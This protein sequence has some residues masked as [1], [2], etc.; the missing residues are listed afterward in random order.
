MAKKVTLEETVEKFIRFYKLIQLSKD[1]FESIDAN[2][3]GN[4]ETWFMCWNAGA[5]FITFSSWGRIYR[6][7]T[8]DYKSIAIS[9]T[10][11]AIISN[12]RRFW[13]E[14]IR[15]FNKVDPPVLAWD[16][17]V[18]IRKNHLEM[19]FPSIYEAKRYYGEN[20]NLDD[21]LTFDNT[22]DDSRYI[23]HKIMD[24]CYY[25]VN[26]VNLKKGKSSISL[27]PAT[28][29]DQRLIFPPIV[30]PEFEEERRKAFEVRKNEIVSILNSRIEQ[31]NN[32]LREPINQ[33]EELGKYIKNKK[34]TLDI[35]IEVFRKELN[36]LGYR[37]GDIGLIRREVESI[38]DKHELYRYGL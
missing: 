26:I 36:E 19:V 9:P 37:I 35:G 18:L 29:I 5:H 17:V 38:R 3:F 21:F 14:G 34:L 4:K 25:Y 28:G 30:T 32:I 22:I 16:P 13:C 15:M 1:T 27:S 6:S 10:G 7:R 24:I 23:P 33:Y 31:E 2:E 20:F 12:D 8:P 11:S